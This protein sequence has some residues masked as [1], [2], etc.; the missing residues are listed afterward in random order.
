[1][2][3][4]RPILNWDDVPVVIDVPYAA[5]LLALSVDYTSRLAQRGV[6]PGHKIGKQW[7]FDKDELRQYIMEH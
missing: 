3:R 5:R 7:R 4:E 1:M 6:L 2:P